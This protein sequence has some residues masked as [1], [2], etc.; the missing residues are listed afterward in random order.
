[1]LW[2]VGFRSPQMGQTF[3]VTLMS[4]LQLVQAAI[5]HQIENKK[6]IE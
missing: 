2:R 3:A 6:I 5:C 4:L 1:M